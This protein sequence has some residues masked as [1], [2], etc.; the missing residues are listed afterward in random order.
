MATENLRG[1][2]EGAGQG[3]RFKSFTASSSGPNRSVQFN[4]NTLRNRVRDFYRN[5]PWITKAVK[6]YK[7]NLIGTGIRPICQVD[8]EVFH[9]EIMDLWE[10]WAEDCDVS[11]RMNFYMMEALTAV[12][13]M[14]NGEQF[15][16]I[17]YVD[18]TDENPMPIRLK[19]FEPDLVDHSYNM[20][21]YNNGNRIV[22]GIELDENERPVAYHLFKEHPGENN[23]DTTRVR[24]PAERIIHIFEPQRPGQ[25]RGYPSGSAA[26]TRI[27]SLSSYEDAELE[28]KKMAAMLFAFITSKLPESAEG[29]EHVFGGVSNEANSA[30][31]AELESGTAQYLEPGEDVKFNEP[32]DVGGS[33]EA[34]MKVNLRAIAACFDVSYEQMTGDLTNV[35]FSSIRAGLNEM[36]RIYR[37]TQELVIIPQLCRRVWILFTKESIKNYLVEAKGYGDKPRKYFKAKWI[38]P[39]WPYVN[40]L[41]EAQ[42]NV[43]EVR[44]GLESRENVVA[45]KGHDINHLDKQ[46]KADNTRAD[47]YELVFDSDARHTNKSGATQTPIDPDT[48]E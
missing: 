32:A 47:E 21:P 11:G 27:F 8:D 46:I 24:I 36:Q 22:S 16:Q 42:A 20:D 14:M 41:Q 13:L 34:F 26:I 35:N 6:S 1:S 12:S 23:A 40:P 5:E 48:E 45:R 15:F 3:R 2:F 25:V 43:L 18:P 19:A 44:A 10:D 37:Q 17:V 39:G 30:F 9:D 4:M 28:R 29:G 33:Y 38:A 7:A 31:A